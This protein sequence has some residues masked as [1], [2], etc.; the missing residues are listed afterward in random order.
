MLVNKSR[1]NPPGGRRCD[2]D[3]E[4]AVNSLVLRQSALQVIITDNATLT[5][6][7]RDGVHGSKRK[8]KT[9]A[10]SSERTDVCGVGA[11]SHADSFQSSAILLRWKTISSSSIPL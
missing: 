7:D 6:K 10:S 9:A 5:Y 11:N 1:E 2:R 4:D 8:G 3:R